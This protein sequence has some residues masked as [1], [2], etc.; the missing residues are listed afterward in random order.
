MIR[1]TKS[2][3]M[4]VEN[5]CVTSFCDTYKRVLSESFLAVGPS[6]SRKYTNGIP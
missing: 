4:Y 1:Y 6:W 5:T 2:E 3:K